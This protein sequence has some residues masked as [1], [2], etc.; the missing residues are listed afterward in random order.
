MNISEAV[1]K[2][3][4]QLCGERDITVN[5]LSNMAGVTQSTVSDIVNGTTYNA[6]IATLKKLCDGLEITIREF[7]DCELFDD[8]EQEV[9]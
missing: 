7:F 3:I 4:F 1:V 8:L 5:A 2:R 6:G 9:H